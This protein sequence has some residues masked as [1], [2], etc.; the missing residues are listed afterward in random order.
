MHPLYLCLF[1]EAGVRDVSCCSNE[2]EIS[3]KS[4][5][6]RPCS[7]TLDIRTRIIKKKEKA[8]VE[9]RVLKVPTSTHSGL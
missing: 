9:F 1:D 6:R 3:P 5:Q 7:F 2:D 8:D 4:L